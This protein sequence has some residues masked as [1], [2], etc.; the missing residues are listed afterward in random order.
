MT[1]KL[2]EKY[3]NNKTTAA[4]SKAVLEWFETP[5]GKQVLQEII[6]ADGDLMERNDLR[7]LI[8][9]LDSE[10][11]FTSIQEKINRK[12]VLCSIRRTDWVGYAAKAAATMLVI[13]IAALF[14]ISHQQYM[15]EQVVEREP[16]L[17]QTEDEQHREI[18]LG[19]GTV[20]HMNSNSKIFVSPDFMRGA[21]E[22]TLTGEAFF[23]VKH[24]PEQP[25]VIHAK[26]STVE[27]LGTAF[28]V[29]S[30]YGENNV[31]VAVVEGAISF[32]AEE[33]S[34]SEGPSVTLLGGQYGYLNLYERSIKVDEMAIDNY[35]S[36]IKGRFVFDEL[37]LQQVCVQLKRLYDLNCSFEDEEIKNLQIT[38]NFSNESVE[39]TLS[40]IS[41]SL[42]I[43]FVKSENRVHWAKKN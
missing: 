6:E 11:L 29:R 19:D 25:F 3:F 36:W 27:V 32:S 35:L 13:F 34:H 39:K 26:Q 21:R 15:V 31:Q 16:V 41:L 7:T 10:R 9:E 14:S 28:N 17:F 12:S 42:N 33:G 38:A 5:E 23:D 43:D 20:V 37:T 22:I 40:V 18:T 30:L 8:P 4:E 24:N 2:A 1:K